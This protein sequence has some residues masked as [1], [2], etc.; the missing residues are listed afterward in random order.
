MPFFFILP[1]W[2]VCLLLGIVL[3]FLPKLRF[4]SAHI[5]LGSTIGLLLS[6]GLSTLAL[7][8]L[9][10]TAVSG[11]VVLI[12]YLAGIGFGGA[13]GIAVGIFAAKKLNGLIASRRLSN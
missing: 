1:L 5:L 11:W 8:L 6:F 9:A 4:L 13:I 3:L 10:K 7:I 12:G 2:L